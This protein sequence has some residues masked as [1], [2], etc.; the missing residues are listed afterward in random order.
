MSTAPAS[1]EPAKPPFIARTIRRLSVLIVL[2]WL[3]LTFLVSVSVPYN[4]HVTPPVG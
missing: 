4:D 1:S 2:A 3:A